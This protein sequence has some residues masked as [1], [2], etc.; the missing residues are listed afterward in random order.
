MSHLRKKLVFGLGLFLAATAA[1]AGAPIR[2]GLVLYFPNVSERVRDASGSMNNAQTDGLVVSNSP[3][4]VSMAQTHQLS[5]CV[6][7]NPASIPNEFP[8]LISKGGNSG[9]GDYGGYEL[10]LNIHGDHD[11]LFYSGPFQAHA[12]T[13]AVNT[14]L[15]QWIHIAFTI[16]TDAQ[17]MQFYING[18]P[19]DVTIDVGTFADINFDQPNDLYVGTPDPRAHINRTSFDGKMREVMLFNR[20]LSAEEVQKIYTKTSEV[21]P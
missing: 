16:D 14:N 9:E 2:N 18:Q 6:W 1:F 17:T 4:L 20:A 5:Y 3:S 19:V 8:E 7:I 11:V 13:H 21:K 12:E 10:S 15:N